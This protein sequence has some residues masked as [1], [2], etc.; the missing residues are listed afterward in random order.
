MRFHE[1]QVSRQDAVVRLRLPGGTMTARQ[2]QELRFATEDIAE[3]HA[4]RVVVIESAGEDFCT[5]FDPEQLEAGLDANPPAV[6]AGLR[7]P[8]IVAVRGRAHS[9]GLEI[10]L[11]ADLCVMADDATFALADVR[12]GRLPSWGGTQRLPRRVGRSRALEMVLLG[13]VLDARQALAWGL[14]HELVE[15]D[16]L[17]ARTEEIVADLL[18][19]G[20]IALQYAKEAIH[21]GSELPMREGLRLE[22]DLNSLLQASQDRAE[23][24][25]AFSEKRAPRFLGR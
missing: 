22:G 15:G 20:P 21:N 24:I 19:R 10:V 17:A 2:A 14:G 25:A 16:R 1:L 13:T 7:P 23:G 5:G 8:V 12:T 9:V 6:L 3:D 18:G 4:A 11:A